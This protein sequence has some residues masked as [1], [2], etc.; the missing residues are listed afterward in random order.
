[1]YTAVQDTPMKWLLFLR[2]LSI[3]YELCKIQKYSERETDGLVKT[4]SFSSFPWKNHFVKETELDIS[5]KISTK[6]KKDTSIKMDGLFEMKGWFW[7][8]AKE[9]IINWFKHEENNEKKNIS[10]QVTRQKTE[11]EA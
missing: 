4:E 11:D 7:A 8:L 9:T 1:M 6:K 10:N 2:P 3:D 5:I